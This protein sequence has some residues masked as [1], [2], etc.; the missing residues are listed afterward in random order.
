MLQDVCFSLFGCLF[1][2]SVANFSSNWAVC[3]FVPSQLRLLTAHPAAGR[4]FLRRAPPSLASALLFSQIFSNPRDGISVCAK[5]YRL[6]PSLSAAAQKG[7]VQLRGLRHLLLSGFSLSPATSSAAKAALK[8]PFLGIFKTCL[9]LRH[10]SKVS[11][12]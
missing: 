9:S 11:K 7:V 3:V 12:S 1:F 6:S 5:F 2:F 8:S 4:T 10:R